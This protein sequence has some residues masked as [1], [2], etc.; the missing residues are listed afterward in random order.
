MFHDFITGFKQDYK[1]KKNY[2][3]N[4]ADEISENNLSLLNS[5]SMIT[6]ILLIFFYLITPLILKGRT[7]TS[8]HYLFFTAV[9]I[10][11]G[12][13][14]MYIKSYHRDKWVIT[15]LCIL[16]EVTTFVFVIYVD[17]YTSPSTASVFL[18]LLYVVF[19]VCFIL[20]FWQILIML[21][22]I[23]LTYII[24][25][26]LIK[27]PAVG[28]NDI[29]TSIAGIVFALLI[30]QVILWYRTKDH[31]IRSRYIQLSMTDS[32]TGILNKKACEE[33]IRKYLE[34]NTDHYCA[35]LFLDLDNFKSINDHTGHATGDQILEGTGKLL[36]NSFRSTDIVGRI[37]GDEF[38]VLIKDFSDSEEALK[39]KC[40]MLQTEMYQTMLDFS[41]EA[42][43][44]IG[45]VLFQN[46]DLDFRTIYKLA[47]ESL[48]KAK[49]AGKNQCIMQSI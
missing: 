20:P 11:I 24:L 12:V 7:L 19:S 30:S 31:Q 17:I 42:S 44:S 33:A 8:G 49:T 18:P 40:A 5:S 28:Q 35:L 32:L 2:F 13:S 9:L 15:L 6:A 23:E 45:A 27:D 29:F 47:D 41:V 22:I 10:F 39:K 25:V 4:A 43:C 1:F 16:F 14:S 26:R 37:G 38:M 34:A 21:F 46:K 36:F 48:Y 3:L